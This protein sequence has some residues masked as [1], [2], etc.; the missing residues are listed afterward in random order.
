MK[1]FKEYLDEIR[2][3][4][5]EDEEEGNQG[6]HIVM[7][8]RKSVTMN[9]QKH[10]RF[11][12]GKTH[13]VPRAHAAKFLSKHASLKTSHEK[14]KL[15]NTAAKSKDHFHSTI[16]DHYEIADKVADQISHLMRHETKEAPAGTYFTRSG[17]LKKGNPASDGPGGAKLASDPL[18]KQRKTIVNLKN[19]PSNKS[20]ETVTE[21]S[22][23]MKSRYTSK[24]TKDLKSRS[25][26]AGLDYSRP[27]G[28]TSA[29]AKR[30]DKKIDNRMKGITKA[31]EDVEQID[32]L[33]PQNKNKPPVL[34]K[35]P[36]GDAS[37]RNASGYGALHRFRKK[38]MQVKTSHKREAVDPDM[39]RLQAAA[40]QKKNQAKRDEKEKKAMAAKAH[41]RMQSNPDNYKP[42]NKED[43]SGMSQKSGDKRSTEAGAGMTAQGVAK[44]NRRTGGNL[45]TAVTTPPSKLKPGSKAANRRKSFCARSRGWTGERGRAA[46][47]RWNC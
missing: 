11:N 25:F 19:H 47:R 35:S 18:D 43:M 9:G 30:N 33:L 12:D 26:A 34:I 22:R 4:S 24:A 36:R 44:Y 13:Q 21:I 16:K 45:K 27:F 17:Q 29:S 14:R 1:S 10:V 20:E 38:A 8:L 42:F 32:E 37:I 7:Q 46:R 6:Q 28:G 23:D 2:K 40:T 39:M 41:V 3:P 31:A 5:A 15:Q